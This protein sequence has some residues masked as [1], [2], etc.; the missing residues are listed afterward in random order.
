ML[1]LPTVIKRTC[2]LLPYASLFRSNSFISS[3]VA[4]PLA[5]AE[6][7]C[8][9]IGISDDDSETP[10]SVIQRRARWSSPGRIHISANTKLRMPPSKRS[11]EHTSELKS[12]MRISY[13]VFCL[14][15][16]IH[17]HTTYIQQITL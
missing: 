11:E 16:K 1:R 12:L 5:I 13:A 15:K 8:E 9:R 14:T 6:W 17:I 10:I 7:T 4:L 3:R 2:T